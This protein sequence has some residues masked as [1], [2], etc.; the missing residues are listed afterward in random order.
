MEIKRAIPP[1]NQNTAPPAHTDIRQAYARQISRAQTQVAGKEDG[2]K[3]EE[4]RIEGVLGRRG[5][6]EPAENAAGK[7]VETNDSGERKRQHPFLEL[8]I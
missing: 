6:E 1:Y 2:D 4:A 5:I 8:G 3:K 7:Q